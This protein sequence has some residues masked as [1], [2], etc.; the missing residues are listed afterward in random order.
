MIELILRN[1]MTWM[2]ISP[3]FVASTYFSNLDAKP[4]MIPKANKTKQ[5]YVKLSSL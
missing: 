1:K 3:Y 2:I 5:A 4:H